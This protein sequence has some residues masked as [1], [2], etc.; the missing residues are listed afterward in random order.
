[1]KKFTDYPYS[2]FPDNQESLAL[3]FSKIIDVLKIPT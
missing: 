1:M 3:I 2:K